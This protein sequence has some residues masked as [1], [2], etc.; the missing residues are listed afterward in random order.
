MS[1]FRHTVNQ[2]HFPTGVVDHLN[3]T[4][5]DIAL[6]FNNETCYTVI[7]DA[8]IRA[9]ELPSAITLCPLLT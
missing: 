9:G 7:R 5:G 1:P 6:S 4:A 2:C 8:G 3:N